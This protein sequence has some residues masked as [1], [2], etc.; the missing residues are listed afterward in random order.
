LTTIMP[1]MASGVLDVLALLVGEEEQRDRRRRDEG[2]EDREQVAADD[3]GVFADGRAADAVGQAAR[4]AVG[5]LGRGQAGRRLRGG[6]GGCY[7]IM[8]LVSGA[9]ARNSTGRIP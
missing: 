9:V 5:G 7:H 1:L 2:V 4:G 6:R 3:V 8:S